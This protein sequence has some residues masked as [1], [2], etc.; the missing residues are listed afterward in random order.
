MRALRAVAVL[1]LACGAV[2][3][4]AEEH[5][6]AGDLGSETAAREVADLF[7][8]GVKA[9]VRIHDGATDTAS[10]DSVRLI[11]TASLKAL[12]ERKDRKFEAT[13][14]YARER[15]L[16]ATH[17]LL[18]WVGTADRNAAIG[19]FFTFGDLVALYGD[20]RRIVTCDVYHPG[21]C[22]LTDDAYAFTQARRTALRD[23]VVGWAVFS[24]LDFAWAQVIGNVSARGRA[25]MMC[26]ESFTVSR[27]GNTARSAPI[28]TLA[29]AAHLQHDKDLLAGKNLPESYTAEVLKLAFTNHW[30]FGHKAVR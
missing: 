22:T 4:E 12:V 13:A 3:F 7:T 23:L 20:V 9:L 17:P 25:P 30:H 14:F 2:A 11:N 16:E 10:G 8:G 21:L 1:V 28:C 29:S 18:V 15:Q 19:G 27:L 6:L 5:K 24:K 26:S